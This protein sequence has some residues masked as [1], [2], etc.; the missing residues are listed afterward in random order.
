MNKSR[1]F[2]LRHLAFVCGLIALIISAAAYVRVQHSL[3]VSE[4][5]AE[6]NTSWI[7]ISASR[8]RW[9]CT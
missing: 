7:R 3:Q 1:K 8:L 5:H 4:G 6:N 9:R 2:A